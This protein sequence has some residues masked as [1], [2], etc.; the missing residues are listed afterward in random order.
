MNTF[1]CT[2]IYRVCVGAGTQDIRD[3]N[4]KI[5]DIP[6][7]LQDGILSVLFSA[8]W[9]ID[10]TEDITVFSSLMSDTIHKSTSSAK[11]LKSCI[12]FARLDHQFE[13]TQSFI[14]NRFEQIDNKMTKQTRE[15][16]KAF[17]WVKKISSNVELKLDDDAEKLLT[18]L[19]S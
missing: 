12:T 1:V 11:A 6:G 16:N 13:K 2:M 5:V 8:K 10:R 19:Q 14:L 7:L 9:F 17:K 15:I 3:M 4:K 18:Q